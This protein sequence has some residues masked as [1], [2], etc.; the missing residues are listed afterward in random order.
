[1][2]ARLAV[3]GADVQAGAAADAVQ[4]LLELR[5]E[6]LGA[7]VVHEDE[8]E[9]LGAVELAFAAGSRDEV[10]VYR[11]LLPRAAAGQEPDEDREVREARDELLYPHHDDVDRGDAGDEPGVA[12]V[13]DGRDGPRLGDPEVGARYADV[14]G[15]ELLAQASAGEGAEGLDVGRQLFARGLRRGSP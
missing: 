3:D 14:S 2:A 11:E 10:G 6:Q 1:M 12:L 9:L 8:M 15:Q 4:R 7:A 5:A 13:G